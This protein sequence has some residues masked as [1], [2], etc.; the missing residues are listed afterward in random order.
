MFKKLLRLALA[1]SMTIVLVAATGQA[2]NQM[3]SEQDLVDNVNAS[4]LKWSGSAIGG[5][6][7]MVTYSEFTTYIQNNGSCGGSSNE[8]MPYSAMTACRI[9]TQTYSPILANASFQSSCA[10]WTLSSITCVSN[11]SQDTGDT[12]EVVY[13]TTT[14]Q[15]VG[16]AAQNFT[17]SGTPTS[18][19]L[20]FYY[21]GTVAAANGDHVNC[22]PAAGSVGVSVKVNNTTFTP[23]LT[24]DGA[25]HQYSTTMSAMV[26]GSNTFTV[27]LSG[28]STENQT[29][30]YNSQ[31]QEYQ[32]NAPTWTT[33]NIHFDN[34]V[35][36][37]TW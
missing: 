18:Q 27:T 26:S 17:T 32:C 10:S 5:S 9:L 4:N 19:T 34:A 24:L 29:S 31:L 28:V 16:T 37:G 6:T 20:S 7:K 33:N 14:S 36:T 1:V 11:S 2:T 15:A 3:L 12:Y 21:R 8:L 22:S 13:N 30:T 23:T 35:L 25:W